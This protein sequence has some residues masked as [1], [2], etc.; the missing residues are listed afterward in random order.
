MLGGRGKVWEGGR[1]LSWTR[2]AKPL[3]AMMMV[4]RGAL[5][6]VGRG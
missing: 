6:V 2:K 4:D 3:A 1:W 5:V